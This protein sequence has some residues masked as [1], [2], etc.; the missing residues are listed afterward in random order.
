MLICGGGGRTAG[1]IATF[2]LIFSAGVLPASASTGATN[3]HTT[4]AVVSAENPTDE[5]IAK[6][7]AQLASANDVLA[8]EEPGSY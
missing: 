1:I 5:D 2:A 8:Q 4:P 7:E 3:Y 6:A